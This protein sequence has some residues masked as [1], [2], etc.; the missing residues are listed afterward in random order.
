MH[1]CGIR[2]SSNDDAIRMKG[3]EGMKFVILL[4]III[5]AIT[6]I[7]FLV[8]TLNSSNDI[9]EASK[10]WRIQG[11]IEAWKKLIQGAKA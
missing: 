4:L 8:L 3:L 2:H 7:T 10:S 11:M 9:V 6:L 1:L 5:G